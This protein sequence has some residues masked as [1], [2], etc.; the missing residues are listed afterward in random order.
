MNDLEDLLNLRRAADDLPAFVELELRRREANLLDERVRLTS[1][2]PMY[3]KFTPQ[4]GVLRALRLNEKLEEA[5]GL[6]FNCPVCEQKHGVTLLFNV[7]SVPKIAKPHGRYT[8]AKDDG[9]WHSLNELTIVE[10]VRSPY[11]EWAGWITK[12]E[13]FWKPRQS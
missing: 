11:C 5:Q 2:S 13:V 12:G 1:L 7:D 10:R 6:N 9:A 3:L 8:P 4:P